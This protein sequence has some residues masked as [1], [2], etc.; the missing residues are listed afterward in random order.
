MTVDDQP[1]S[2]DSPEK[3]IVVN[4]PE[5]FAKTRQ[6]RAIF[7]AR[8]EYIEKRREAN[9][10]LDEHEIDFAGKNR[11]IFLHLQDLAMSMEPLL[12]SY[13]DGQRLWTEKTYTL[14][15]WARPGDVV[16]VDTALRHA[17]QHQPE[18]F[19][20]IKKE[21]QENRFSGVSF[22][23]EKAENLAIW[24]ASDTGVE[25]QG[26]E[27]LVSRTPK[28]RYLSSNRKDI[29]PSPPPQSLSDEAFRDMQRFISDIGLGVDIQSE[30][31]T[32]IDDGLLEEVD[33]WR[34]NNV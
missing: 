31:Q 15:D 7:D 14:D 5:D 9:K 30:Q 17:K 22:A 1:G 26:L 27:A 16:D 25:L 10:L 6:L 34:Q 3:Q 33:K 11:L 20:D 32:K 21:R 18:L 23:Q 13:D 8:D 12:K 28:L 29:C 4:D 19:E 24:V 2:Q